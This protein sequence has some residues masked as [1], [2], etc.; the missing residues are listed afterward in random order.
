MPRQG[1]RV[2]PHC[3][4]RAA[5]CHTERRYLH[6]AISDINISSQTPHD[7]D[8]RVVSGTAAAGTTHIARGTIDP[9]RGGRSLRAARLEATGSIMRCQYHSAYPRTSSIAQSVAIA[10]MSVL[11]MSVLLGYSVLCGYFRH[12]TVATMYAS[13]T[14]EIWSSS[15]QQCKA[16][17]PSAVVTSEAVRCGALVHGPGH[18]G[19]LQRHFCAW[20]V[21]HPQDDLK[22]KGRVVAAPATP[23]PEFAEGNDE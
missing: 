21:R 20:H 12:P 15:T 9:L 3:V 10:D 18:G 19:M 5:A 14:N 17:T 1:V 7:V 2:Y 16:R 13:R 4:I 6:N 11:H 22:P 23:P 8:R